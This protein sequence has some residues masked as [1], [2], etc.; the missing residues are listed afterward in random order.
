MVRRLVSTLALTSAIVF[1]LAPT[2][3]A[4]VA[5]G[6]RT[7][8][9]GGYAWN[10]SNSMDYTGTPGGGSFKLH[11]AFT[12]DAALPES[13]R[14]IR[15]SDGVT[16]TAPKK[17]SGGAHAEGSSLAAAG[18][19]VIAGWMTGYSYYDAAG[20]NRRVQ[21]NVSMDN[22]ATWTGVDNL[23]SAGGFV[24]Y[25]IVAAGVVGDTDNVYVTWVDSVSGKVKFRQ[26]SDGGSTWSSPINLGTTTAQMEGAAF[27]Y[28]GFAN[29][30]AVGNLVSVAWIAD[31][32]GTLKVRSVNAG[33]VAAAPATLSNWNGIKTLTDKIEVANGDWPIVSSSPAQSGVITIGYGTSTAARYTTYTG[34]SSSANAAGKTIW[35]VGSLGGTDYSGTYDTV[36]EPAPGGGFV[37]QW[38][39][40]QDTTADCDWD[41]SAAKMDL[42]GSTSADGNTWS[43]PVKLEVSGNTR[44]INDEPSIVVIPDAAG[45]KVFSQYNAY[46]WNYVYYDVWLKTGTGSL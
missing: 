38:T 21:V 22:G 30:A 36:V 14:Y 10:Y 39:G 41:S 25:P 28:S 9:P 12:T 17:V 16:W 19:T 6:G 24:D 8:L 33:G 4:A 20:A 18:S 34:G 32:T 3:S 23:S 13:V 31:P 43:A 11:D 37:A 44:Q 29:I 15:S 5:Y 46:K 26:S 27:G 40:C 42:I 45:V 7:N 2:A 35:T 1:A